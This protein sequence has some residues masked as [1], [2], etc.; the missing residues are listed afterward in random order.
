MTGWVLRKQNR[1]DA[2]LLGSLG[3]SNRFIHSKTG[4]SFGQINYA[5]RQANVYRMQF[6]NGE[7]PEAQSLLRQ[8]RNVAENTLRNRWPVAPQEI[9]S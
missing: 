8:Y 7:S 9:K 2:A 5:L 1:F 3:F 6:R 4:L